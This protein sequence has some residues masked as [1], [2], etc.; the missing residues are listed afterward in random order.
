MISPPTRTSCTDIQHKGKSP[1]LSRYLFTCHCKDTLAKTSLHIFAYS[2]VSTCIY[3]GCVRPREDFYSKFI[4]LRLSIV[5]MHACNLELRLSPPI[6]SRSWNGKSTITLA[7][8]Y[9][10]CTRTSGT[11]H[12]V[13]IIWPGDC[14]TFF[15]KTKGRH[16]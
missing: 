8:H 14:H 16:T 5:N 13:K 15:E 2:Y 12:S 3:L 1:I 11:H 9:H 6:L 7:R 10:L 4:L